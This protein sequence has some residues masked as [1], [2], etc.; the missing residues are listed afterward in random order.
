MN[1]PSKR[2]STT[3]RPSNQLAPGANSSSLFP[4]KCRFLS[5]RVLTIVS[6]FGASHASPASLPGY[7]TDGTLFTA[8]SL[9]HLSLRMDISLF[10]VWQM[11]MHLRL[12]GVHLLFVPLTALPQFVPLLV[13]IQAA[14]LIAMPLEFL[15][16]H[17]TL[18]SFDLLSFVIFRAHNLALLCLA[19]LPSLLLLLL[20]LLCCC[21]LLPLPLVLGALSLF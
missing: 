20:L 11:S 4:C 5:V 13:T 17:R 2:P 14:P 10:R 21:L 1:S 9:L 6:P 18:Q 15:G 7:W 8:I 3:S 19:L 16:R 12:L